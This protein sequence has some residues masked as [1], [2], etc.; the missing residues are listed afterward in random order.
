MPTSP[1]FPVTSRQTF[2]ALLGQAEALRAA[3]VAAGEPACQDVLDAYF[4]VLEHLAG[5]AHG[6]AEVFD[7]DALDI[8]H[9]ALRR[10]ARLDGSEVAA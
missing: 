3:Q 2:E 8:P 9:E 1:R 4:I 10:Y 5:V 7:D 6:E